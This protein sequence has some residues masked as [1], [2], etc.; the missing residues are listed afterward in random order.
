MSQLVK[1]HRITIL[2]GYPNVNNLESLKK[3]LKSTLY[4]LYLINYCIRKGKKSAF[5]VVKKR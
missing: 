4:L 3:F 2:L 1:E 5:I